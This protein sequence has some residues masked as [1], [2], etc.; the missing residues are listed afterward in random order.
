MKDARIFGYFDTKY[1]AVLQIEQILHNF[2][3]QKSFKSQTGQFS[4]DTRRLDLL[5]VCSLLPFY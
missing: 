5:T 2:E 1:M 3:D 4:R